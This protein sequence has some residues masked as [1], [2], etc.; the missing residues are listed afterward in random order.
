MT[1]S[2]T[3]RRLL[4]A[5]ADLEPWKRDHDEAQSCLDVEENLAW[6]VN[7]YRGLLERESRKSLQI[8][9]DF[10]QEEAASFF[11]EMTQFYQMWLNAS[12]VYL[13]AARSFVGS[14]YVVDGLDAFEQTVEEARCL[15]GNLALES[16]IR[17]IEELIALA[18]PENPRPE[19]YGD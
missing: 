5:Y 14:G 7:L 9:R 10:D 2:R 3:T 13:D 19:R 6:G 16:E 17:P 1:A 8:S 18:K 15:L 12:E 4:S 11:A